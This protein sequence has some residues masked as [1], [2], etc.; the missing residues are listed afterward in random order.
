MQKIQNFS[1]EANQLL[2]EKFKIKNSRGFTLMEVLLYISIFAIVGGFLVNILFGTLRVQT[3]SQ[4]ARVVSEQGRFV[5]ET[6]KRLVREASLIDISTTTPQSTL[7]LRTGRYVN[8][9]DFI[10][11]YA[12]GSAIYVAEGV[13]D[14]TGA[15]STPCSSGVSPACNLMRLTDNNISVDSLSFRRQSNAPGYDALQVDLTL[16]YTT[17][18]PQAKFKKSFRTAIGRVSAAVFDSNL[19]PNT[20]GTHSVGLNSQKWLDGFFSRNL[21]VGGTLTALGET[22]IGANNS[23]RVKTSTNRVGIGT[24]NPVK[25]LHVTGGDVYISSSSAG[26]ILKSPDGLV[27]TRLEINNSGG[28]ATSSVTCP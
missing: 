11:V 25:P 22:T 17:E 20:G 24:A 10:H 18:K 16:S 1:P 7:I 3:E 21:D 28:F 15:S 26:I 6:I 8:N 9:K 5:V 19:L 27:C 12:S 4:S 13:I 2:A 14:D 23:L